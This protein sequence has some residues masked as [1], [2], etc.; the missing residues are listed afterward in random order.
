MTLGYKINPLIEK[1]LEA[2]KDNRLEDIL[3]TRWDSPITVKHRDYPFFHNMETNIKFISK[4]SMFRWVNRF[5]SKYGQ[6]PS[7]ASPESSFS[8]ENN[9]R[10][11]VTGNDIVTP[12]GLWYPKIS[13]SFIPHDISPLSAHQ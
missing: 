5:S 8:D 10:F 2:I 13:S 12:N 1:K 9:V 6:P 3:A 7:E 4:Q 11:T